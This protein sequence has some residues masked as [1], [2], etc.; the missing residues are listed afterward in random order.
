MG[1]AQSNK[2]AQSDVSQFEQVEKLEATNKTWR[3]Y[4]SGDY[5]IRVDTKEYSWGT[6]CKV[7]DKTKPEDMTFIDFIKQGLYYNEFYIGDLGSTVWVSVHPN[8]IYDPPDIGPWIKGERMNAGAYGVIVDNGENVTKYEI[9]SLEKAVQDMFTYALLL[10]TNPDDVLQFLS[11]DI[12]VILPSESKVAFP[13][14][15]LRMTKM[16]KAETFKHYLNNPPETLNDEDLVERIWSIAENYIL[17][18]MKPANTVVYKDDFKF[19]DFDSSFVQE[20]NRQQF[21]FAY[22]SYLFIMI[23]YRFYE[24]ED[25][26]ENMFESVRTKL[27]GYTRNMCESDAKMIENEKEGFLRPDSEELNRLM[28]HYGSRKLDSKQTIFST[29]ADFV[30]ALQGI[31]F[32]N[33][34]KFA[35]TL[36]VKLRF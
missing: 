1:T 8:K 11:D 23:M 28:Q 10:K 6:K 15:V 7:K 2:N 27:A 35:S 18:D 4:K 21:N 31:T 26:I 9:L 12:K 14:Y 36:H 17:L 25:F 19:I 32:A 5:I 33:L 29:L 22:M 16:P 30:G 34:E 24:E 3:F 20:S 13:T